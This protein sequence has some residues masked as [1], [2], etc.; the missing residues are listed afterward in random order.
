MILERRLGL[1]RC[2]A[3][4]AHW[5]STCVW[6]AYLNGASDVLH[7]ARCTDEVSTLC[8]MLTV[9][10]LSQLHLLNRRIRLEQLI[11]HSAVHQHWQSR[12]AKHWC[13]AYAQHASRPSADLQE[14]WPASTQWPRQSR[15]AD[16]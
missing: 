8:V 11:Q 2:W 10:C 12:T 1:L 9:C 5:P 7:G 3:Q 13:Q 6:K 4:L 16:L 15:C 14:G